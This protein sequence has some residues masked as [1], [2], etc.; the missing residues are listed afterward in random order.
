M[1]T[2]YYKIQDINSS[3]AQAIITETA[4]ALRTGELVAFPTETVYGLGANGF[5][6]AAVAKIFATKGRPGDN[7][8]IL[9]IAKQSMLAEI[10]QGVNVRAELLMEAFWPGPLTIVLPKSA[11]VPSV[12]SGGLATVAVRWPASLIAQALILASGVPI[13]APSANTSGRPSPTSAAAVLEDLDGKIAYVIDGGDCAVGLESTVVDCT[14]SIPIVLRPGSVT[15]EMI[16]AVLGEASLQSFDL[17]NSVDVPRAPGMKYR[18]YAPRSP[19]V[20]VDVNDE[21]QW[22]ELQRQ[23]N[24]TSKSIGFIGS[25]E[26]CDKLPENIFCFVLA[27]KQEI[28]RAAANLFKA[29]RKMDELNIELIFAETWP[30]VGIGTAL[31]NRLR[32]AAGNSNIL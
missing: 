12:T 23:L 27:K 14:G 17:E 2:K 3:E 8:L 5:E 4:L 28:D 31:M 15:Q 24:D 13:A 7:P 18:H 20:L 21:N 19:L 10:V 1:K 32:K 26:S 16:E 25:K 11:A 22:L 29:I 6:A 30:D 9:H